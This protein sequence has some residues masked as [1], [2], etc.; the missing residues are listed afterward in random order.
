MGR[1][2]NYLILANVIIFIIVFSFPEEF[3]SQAFS[4]LSYSGLEIVQ[5]WRWITSLFLHASATHLFFNMLGLYFFGKALE[6]EVRPRTWIMIYFLSGIAGNVIF[7]FTSASAVVGASGCIFGLMG[8]AMLMKPKEWIKIFVIPLPLGIVAVF[9]AIVSTMLVFFNPI[10]AVDNV[11][12][13]AHLTGLLVGAGIIFFYHTKKAM[14]N[15]LW[16]VLFIV[17]LIVLA[18]LFGIIFGIGNFI[19]SIVDAVIGF[20]L[21]GLAFLLSLIWSALI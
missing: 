12:H 14:K 21:Y 8:A 9:Y 18:P 15:T 6:K 10:I 16:L 17:L 7:G 19:L 2:T 4:L 13:I 3:M 11:A 5:A 1:L 20:F